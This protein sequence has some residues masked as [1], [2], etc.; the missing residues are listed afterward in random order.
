VVD[1]RAAF[2]EAVQREVHVARRVQG[3]P[4]GG[5]L[6]GTAAAA[7]ARAAV[8]EALVARGLLRI[9]KR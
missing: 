7:V 4:P 2:T 6:D 9:L 3:H 5:P 1:E 8:R